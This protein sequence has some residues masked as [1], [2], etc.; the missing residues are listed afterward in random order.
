MLWQMIKFYIITYKPTL[1]QWIEMTQFQFYK[2]TN[3]Q[4]NYK[5]KKKSYNKW[6]FCV[7][8]L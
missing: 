4:Q 3:C 5:L 6:Y 8:T 2:G 7:Y 1:F